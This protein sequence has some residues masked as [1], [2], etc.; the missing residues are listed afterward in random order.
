MCPSWSITRRGDGGLGQENERWGG[1]CRGRSTHRIFSFTK[2]GVCVRLIALALVGQLIVI[3]GPAKPPPPVTGG[4]AWPTPCTGSEVPLVDLQT[5]ITAASEGDVL[6]LAA[7]TVNATAKI[8]DWGTKAI[9]LRGAGN[10]PSTCPDAS[11]AIFTGACGSAGQTIIY[12]DTTDAAIGGT[13]N[14]V[15][16]NVVEN[17]KFLFDASSELSGYGS[18]TVNAGDLTSKPAIIRY[19]DFVVTGLCDA[20]LILISNKGGVVSRNRFDVEVLE[21]CG[22]G[23]TNAVPIISSV[24]SDDTWWN[25]ASTF[26]SAD[27]TGEANLYVEQNLFIGTNVTSDR[28]GNSRTAWRFNEM[29][30]ASLGGHG[31]DSNARGIRAFETYNN[32]FVCD[33][34]FQMNIGVWISDRGGTGFTHSNTFDAYNT[35]T[36]DYTGDGTAYAYAFT[37]NRAF[38]ASSVGAWPGVYPDTY[39]ISHQL[40]WGWISGSNQTVGDSTT[41]NL[42]GG[43]GFAQALEPIWVFNNTNNVTAGLEFI[44]Q[45]AQEQY[46]LTYNGTRKASGTTVTAS[47]YMNV[48]QDV[49]VACTDLIGGSALTIADGANTFTALTG[50]TNGS[51]RLSAWRMRVTTGGQM[52]TVTVTSDSSASA[53][54]CVMGVMRGV[55]ASGF[56]KNPAVLS[57]S[58]SPYDGPLSTVLAQANEVVIGYFGL[59]G[60]AV[61]S[62]VTAT[63]TD[64]VSAASP[65]AVGISAPANSA[66]FGIIGTT[67]G[68]ANTN[69]TTA[70]TYRVVT[71]TTSV[72]PRLTNTTADRTGVAGTVTFKI[73]NGAAMTMLV[74]DFMQQGR[75]IQSQTNAASCVASGACTLGIGSGTFAQLPT[76]C[77]PV[78]GSGTSAAAGVGFWVTDRGGDWN[79]LGGGAND[80]ALYRCTSTNTWTLFYTPKTYPHALAAP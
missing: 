27:T 22:W 80:G 43:S 79:T 75:E 58:T 23:N 18:I 4:S 78:S 45:A 70:L 33:P 63:T 20:R 16:S 67:G 1:G 3:A 62:S 8:G 5:R 35:S 2:F 42:P 64:A 46:L 34:S 56:D 21:A 17:I 57:D 39:P 52:R 47:S 65:D 54:S 13:G 12:H 49:V 6:C 37:I 29:R 10:M 50:G 44:G 32:H 51:L 69:T 7:G 77:T 61:Y 40:G 60:P 38:Q 72:A 71:A 15:N 30:S 73:T 11:G 53:I 31:Y 59:Q 28:T 74:T 48:G 66:Q 68:A 76:S 55:E 19:N 41:Q 25:S 26:G 9:T 36:C 14:A 24:G